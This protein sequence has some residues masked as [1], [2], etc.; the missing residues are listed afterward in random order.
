MH[1]FSTP[2]FFFKNNAPSPL[3]SIAFQQITLGWRLA[4][5]FLSLAKSSNAQLNR[6]R[7]PFGQQ[8]QSQSDVCKQSGENW[9]VLIVHQLDILETMSSVVYCILVTSDYTGWWTS[10]WHWRLI[11]EILSLVPWR[12]NDTNVAVINSIRW[13]AIWGSILKPW[14]KTVIFKGKNRNPK[15]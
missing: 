8:T 13:F 6:K 4:T 3:P 9:Q 2:L 7:P 12:V 5:K 14:K 10:W 15:L 1:Q 11:Y